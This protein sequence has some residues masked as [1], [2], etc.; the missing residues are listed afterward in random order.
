M[1]TESFELVAFFLASD[2]AFS[3][4]KPRMSLLNMAMLLAVALPAMLLTRS[5]AGELPMGPFTPEASNGDPFHPSTAKERAKSVLFGFALSLLLSSGPAP[6]P[7]AGCRRGDGADNV[8]GPG[9]K[10]H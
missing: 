1:N 9:A 8:E 4:S 2:R 5:A 3:F 6:A 7:A 10:A